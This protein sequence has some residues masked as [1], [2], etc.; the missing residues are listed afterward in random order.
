M[1]SILLRAGRREPTAMA[2]CVALSALG[3]FVYNELTKES[4][5]PKIVDATKVILM[6]LKV[7]ESF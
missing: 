4:F 7:T 5:H 6:A 3:M 2:R 1:V